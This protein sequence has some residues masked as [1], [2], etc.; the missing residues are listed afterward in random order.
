MPLTYLA[1]KLIQQQFLAVLDE[2]ILDGTLAAEHKAVIL[3]SV[4]YLDP[5][6]VKALESFIKG[7][8]LVLL[9]GDCTVDVPGAVKLAVTPKMPDQAAID[10][11]MKAKK[12]DQLGPYQTTGKFLAGAAPLGKAIQAELTRAGIE[13]I[14]VC[15]TPTIIATRQ[16][17]GDIEYLFA[18]NATYDEADKQ[19]P[20]NAVKATA[21]TITLANDGKHIYDALQGGEVHELHEQGD[22]LTG[23]FRF[24]PGQM[25]V[26]ARTGRRIGGVRQSVPVVVRDFTRDSSAPIQV[27]IAATLVDTNGKILSGSAPLHIRLIDPLGVTRYELYRATKQGQLAL[28]L[29]LATNDPPGEW[30]VSIRELLNNGEET[31]TFRYAPPPRLR[32]LVGSTPR[33]IYAAND[34]DNAF[35]FARSHHDITLVKGSSPFHDAAAKRLAKALEP[36]GM[37]CKEMPVAEAAKSRRLTEEEALTWCGL[38]YAAKGQIKAGDSNLPVVAG[39]AVQGPVILLGNPDDNPLI[40]FLLTERFLPYKPDANELPGRNRGMI[41][42]QRD[43]IGPGQES[44]ALIAY[45]E[46]GINEAV[47]TFYEAVAGIEPLTKW[48]WPQEDAL[49]PAKVAPDKQPTATLAWT[50]AL[51]DRV[52]GMKADANGLTVLTHDG[53]RS[54]VSAEGKLAS[55]NVLEGTA[56]EQARKELPAGDANLGMNVNKQARPD[57]LLKLSASSGGM[58][59]VGYLGGTLRV[60]DGAGTI[61]AERKLPTDI[62]ALA[63]LGGKLIAGLADGRVMALEVK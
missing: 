11:I 25:R 10:E 18:V 12:Y 14:F 48:T 22:R 38:T 13:P 17:Q 20:K 29:P 5:Q 45:D 61:L 58:T 21:A 62:T 6:V 60:I 9:T 28:S 24:G 2:D 4:D 7:G 39:F 59:A 35:R 33:A 54:I 3:T 49:I 41:A 1:G 63:W 27:E 53:S 31:W 51:P 8:G 34:R 46:A 40:K 30:R 52:D 57:R 15:D 56:L 50:V 44:I 42:W 43:A 47:G 23:K 55:T 36:W 16:G 32:S 37:R 26:F 19:D